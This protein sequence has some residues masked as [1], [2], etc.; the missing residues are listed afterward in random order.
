MKRGGATHGFACRF[1]VN[2]AVARGGDLGVAGE[3]SQC[4]PLWT[5]FGGGVNRPRVFCRRKISTPSPLVLVTTYIML[6]PVPRELLVTIGVPRDWV[7]AN[8]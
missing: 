7:V 4:K 5:I 3:W 1:S 8:Q 6:T 2:P